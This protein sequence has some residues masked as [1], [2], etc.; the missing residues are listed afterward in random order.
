M[1]AHS[2]IWFTSLTYISEKFSLIF[3]PSEIQDQVQWSGWLL[4]GGLVTY[5][6]LGLLGPIKVIDRASHLGGMVVGVLC[7]QVYKTKELNTGEVNERK[8]RTR[9]SWYDIVMGKQGG[10]EK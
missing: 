4:L 3:L 7:A 8:S 2:P 5:E 6:V 9:I 10:G 1:F